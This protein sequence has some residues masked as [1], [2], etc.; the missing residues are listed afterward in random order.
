MFGCENPKWY[1]LE[2]ITGFEDLKERV[3]IDWGKGTLAWVQKHNEQNIKEVI[4]ILPTGYVKEFS[5]YFDFT[6]TYNELKKLTEYPEANKRWIDKLSPVNGI[7]LILD[8]KTGSQYIG[9]AYG[10][11]G[12]W[13]R[14]ENYVNTKGHGGNKLLIELLD[15][16]ENYISNLQWTIFETLPANL[17]KDRVI[18]Y[19][20]RYKD[21][22]G[23]RAFGLNAN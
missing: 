12:I 3:I 17:S 23:T 22:L 9:S 8:K 14:W 19:E 5:D 6:L 21:K 1:D 20:T 4:E 11:N 15:K 2:S 16:D 18:L 13:G 7:Y 10:V